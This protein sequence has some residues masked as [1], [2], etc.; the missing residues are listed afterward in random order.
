LLLISLQMQQTALHG[1]N[2]QLP[3]LANA[4]CWLQNRG[5]TLAASGWL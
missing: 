1:L 3:A 4:P 2:H 5:G